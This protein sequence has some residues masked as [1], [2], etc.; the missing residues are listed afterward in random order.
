[1]AETYLLASLYC[2]NG[3]PPIHAPRNHVRSRVLLFRCL[4]IFIYQL[5]EG[6]KSEGKQGIR[7]EQVAKS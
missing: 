7:L 1:M 2:F 4:A 6:K 3:K 5:C